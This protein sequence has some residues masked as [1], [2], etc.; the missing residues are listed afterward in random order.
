M[1]SGEKLCVEEVNRQRQEKWE[2]RKPMDGIKG[3]K[4]R[5]S[6][7]IIP[8]HLLSAERGPDTAILHVPIIM[9]TFFLFQF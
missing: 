2:G 9:C 8:A 5:D 1:G 3:P 6:Q 7:I 4:G